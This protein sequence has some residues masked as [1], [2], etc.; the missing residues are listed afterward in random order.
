MSAAPTPNPAPAQNPAPTLPLMHLAFIL[1]GFGTLLLGPILPLLAARWHLD[2]GHTGL[3]LL[4]QFCGSFLGGVTTSHRLRAGML[5]GLLAAT[6]GLALFA[7]APALPLA[8]A[9]LLLAGFGIGRTI[10]CVNI[11]AGQR[12]STHR[13]S[14]LARINFTWSA[15]ALLSPLLAAALTPRFPLPHLLLAFASLFA[16]TTVILLLQ[17][18]G[19]APE[20]RPPPTTAANAFP[21]RLFLLFTAILFLYGGLETSLSAW[22]TTFALRF[23]QHSLVLSQYTLVLLLAGLAAGRAAAS[24]LLLRIPDRTLILLALALSTLLTAALAFAHRASLIATLA[25]LL[26]F[27]LAPIF[28]ALFAL[29]LNF[30]P[31]A[32]KAAIA[33][34]ATGLGAAALPALMGII[35]TRAGSL[36]FALTLPAAAALLMFLLTALP[37]AGDPISAPPP[38]V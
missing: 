17:S 12:F 15:G 26:G 19:A 33:I 38:S 9:A 18:R 13:A 21:P 3:L 11:L 27:T 29:L 32:R 24:W 16:A 4:A 5:E 2:D 14:A 10:T 31:P 23:G 1:T 25:V 22:L 6:A 20:R 8:C 7:L 30:R 36:Q 37:A 28:P 34:A 35:S